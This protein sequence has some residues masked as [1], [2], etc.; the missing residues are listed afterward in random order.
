MQ[1]QNDFVIDY[2]GKQVKVSTVLD[3]AKIFFTVHLPIPFT[4]AEKLQGEDWLWYDLDEGETER[5][6]EIGK[7]LE[8]MEI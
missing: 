7:I 2:K 3:D 4:I 5:A 6:T 8:D 1:D